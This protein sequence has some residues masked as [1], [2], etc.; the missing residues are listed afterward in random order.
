MK[1]KQPTLY[2]IITSSLENKSL[3]HAY[4]LVGDAFLLETALWLGS[5]MI[6][7]SLDNSVL[8]ETREQMMATQGIDFVL[9]DGSSA[10][11][12]KDDILS[13]QEKFKKTALQASNQKV[14]IIHQVHNAN[15][16]ALNSILK[17]LE[18]PSGSTTRFILTTD[19][20][21]R[22]MPTILSRCVV[23][24]LDKVKAE[25]WHLETGQHPIIEA[26]LKKVCSTLEEAETLLA[27]KSYQL[28]TDIS[29]D[30]FETLPNNVDLALVQWQLATINDREMLKYVIDISIEHCRALLYNRDRKNPFSLA[31]LEGIMK[32]FNTLKAKLNPSVHVNLLVDEGCYLLQE[33]FYVK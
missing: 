9:I 15:H 3:S 20:I 13:L 31:Q 25:E 21:G 24:S 28:A 30:L 6:S 27:N 2:K 4:L 10:L 23:I 16:H 18:E 33:V 7:Q 32:S 22:V 11:I 12:K 5:V 14:V 19:T 1:H 26:H 17:F 8:I 29:V